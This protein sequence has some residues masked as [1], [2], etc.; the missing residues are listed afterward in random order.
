MIEEERRIIGN[1]YVVVIKGIRTYFP[2]EYIVSADTNADMLDK[3]EE[4]NIKS[5]RKIDRL[6]L[7]KPEY[8]MILDTVTKLITNTM[9]NVYRNFAKNRVDAEIGSDLRPYMVIFSCSLINE[10]VVTKRVARREIIRVK[11]NES[12]V[13]GC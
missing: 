10:V 6:T 2:S 12:R 11:L 1:E 13:D 4:Y 8:I 3:L 9:N 7:G 5:R